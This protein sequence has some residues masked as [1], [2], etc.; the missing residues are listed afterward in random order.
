MRRTILI[1]EDDP[2]IVVSLTFLFE[3]AGHQVLAAR[4]GR[5][6]LERARADEPDLIVLD[7]M[8][9]DLTGFDVLK[10]LRADT[11]LRQPKVLMLT[12]KGQAADRRLA[13]ELGTDEYLSKPFSNKGRSGRRLSASTR[14][15]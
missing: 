1:A 14:T 12:A 11:T 7:A 9:H 8:M 3:Q 13:Y 6:A 5:S 2:S 4:D 10:T 15:P